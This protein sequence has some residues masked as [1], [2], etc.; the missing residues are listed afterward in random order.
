MVGNF[1]PLDVSA[2]DTQQR[3]A[4][5]HSSKEAEPIL[6]KRS[7]V[8]H[9]DEAVEHEVP[10]EVKPFLNVRRESIKLPPD[11]ETLGIQS[12]QTPAIPA[13]QKVILPL[14]D[15]KIISGLHAPITSSLR[16]LAT[17]A[18]YMLLQAHLT[19]RIVGGKAVRV[20]RRG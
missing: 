19:L 4:Y 11:L 5:V 16:W 3:A 15:E 8:S 9:L 17:L 12:S 1:T 18:M 6:S 2:Y 13:Y 10:E 14:P 20:A 7:E